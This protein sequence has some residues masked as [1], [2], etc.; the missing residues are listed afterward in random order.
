VE[1]IEA[2]QVGDVRIPDGFR[3]SFP[4]QSSGARVPKTVDEPPIPKSVEPQTAATVPSGLTATLW[5]NPRGGASRAFAP[6][7]NRHQDRL[8]PAALRKAPVGS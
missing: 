8:E 3:P 5:L 1:L 4:E 6:T 2:R 7:R